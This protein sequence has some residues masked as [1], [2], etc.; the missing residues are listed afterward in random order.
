M[1]DRRNAL[2]ERPRK[3]K[4][5]RSS[6]PSSSESDEWVEK[7][8]ERNSNASTSRDDWMSM[9]G[10]LKTFTKDDIKP[11]REDNDKKRIDSYNPS[12]SSRELNPYWK[13]GGTGIPQTSE[14]FRKSN[15]FIK[16]KDED[17]YYSKSDSNS[18]SSKH[19]SRHGSKRRH[20]EKRK[21]DTYGKSYNWKK[22]DDYSLEYES[23]VYKET[24]DKI[25][26]DT[27]KQNTVV[28]NNLCL[29]D[30]KLN[31]LAAK[32]VKAEIMG[33]AKLVIELKAKLQAAKDYRKQN[34][35]HKPTNVDKE[36][37][38]LIKTTPSGSSRPVVDYGD[39]IDKK[40]KVKTHNASGRVNYFAND[41]KYDISRMFEQE[42]YGSNHKDEVQFAMAA[43]KCKESDNLED[44][45]EERISQNK[46][47]VKESKLDEKYAIRQNIKMERSQENC[48]YCFE[49][50][51]MLKHLMISCGSK[52]YLSLPAKRSL[53]EGHCIITTI[54]HHPCVTSVDE[55]V[56]E[57]IMTYRNMITQ[58]FNKQD[59][60]VVF[61]ETAIKLFRFPHLAIN[62]VPLPRDVGDMAAIYFKKALLEC[63]T[64]W[65]MNKKVIE[66]KG[67]NV[68][69]GVPKGLPYFW[70]DFGM[71]PGFAHVIEDQ[72]DF[73]ETFAQQIIGG[74]LDLDHRLWKNPQGEIGEA[75][76]KKVLEFLKEWK[77]FESMFKSDTKS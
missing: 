46:R 69:K 31:K 30:E 73:P 66:L 60:D 3:K 61:F 75:Q 72:H 12:T 36:A 2:L 65:S 43:S 5:R 4:I 1:D 19:R 63:E 34:P 54:H 77:P 28:T 33:D 32:I 64:E 24:V 27:D 56:W 40:G 68:R 15:T 23:S 45:F 67:K 71:D 20:D 25:K 21:D 9:G 7:K 18:K 6:G 52:V 13:N 11:K 37:V 44:L 50:K 49:S 29:S 35:D 74:M 22:K 51:S 70:V 42:K 48:K 59:K 55:D 57:E 17:S 39:N 26:L 41:D 58:F 8:V 62:C 16:P 47:A 53:V 38:L 14:Q 76:R 10:A